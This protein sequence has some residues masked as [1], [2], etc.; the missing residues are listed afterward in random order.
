MKSHFLSKAKFSMII[1]VLGLGTLWLGQRTLLAWG[2]AAANPTVTVLSPSGAAADTIGEGNDYFTQV[3]HEPRDMNQHTDLIWQEFGVNNI[4]FSN[5]LW[6][7]TTT[8]SDGNSNIYMLYPGYSDLTTSVGVAEVG[9]T[10]WNYPIQTSTYKQLSFRLNAPQA[11]SGSWWNV[12]YTNLSFTLEINHV[13]GVYQSGWQVYKMTMPWGS[14]PM[15]GIGYRFGPSTG[16]YQFDWIRLTDP[17]TSPVYAI[18]FSVGNTRAGDVVDLDCYTSAAASNSTYCGSIATGLAVNTAG[19][20]R[21]NWH[22]AYLPPGAYFVHAT[23]RRGASSASDMS[24]GPVTIKPAPVLNINAPSMTSG[25]DYATAE[26]GN[27]WDM[28]DDSDIVHQTWTTHD[29]VAPCPCFENGELTGTVQR[30]DSGVAPGFSD[31]FVYLNVNRDRPIDT[32]KYK[33]MTFRYKIDR[34]P[35]WS[36]SGD[37]LSW[38]SARGVYPAAWLARLIFF[39]TYSPSIKNSSDSTKPLIAFDDW[40][41]YQIDLSKGVQRG[42]WDPTVA[43]TGGTW[44]GLKYW[45][46]FDFLEGTDPWVVHLDYVKLTGDNTANGSFTVKWSYP[47][48][49]RPNSLDFY[50][51]QNRNTCLANGQLISHWQ[52]GSSGVQQPLTG[53]Y[54]VYLPAMSSPTSSSL[55]SFVWNTAAVSSGTYYICARASNAYNTFATVSETPVIVSH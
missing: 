26:L 44:T 20:Y 14:S 3:L 38:D 24:S 43:H 17:A 45:I 16:T 50:A 13:P 33:Y 37:R 19:T 47:E 30:L 22:T 28:S 8:N 34:T 32:S 35:W 1:S 5:G 25:P 46:R 29:F 15:Y 51:G 42:Y 31:P 48:A 12:T 9:K 6:S 18:A 52:A 4:S 11:A 10:G 36:H 55:D 23:V 39:G 40:N 49:G 53:P 2:E 27:P 54:F 41:T 7:G 21:Y